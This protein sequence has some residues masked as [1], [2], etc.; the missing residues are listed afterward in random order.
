MTDQ[1]K[2]VERKLRIII[3]DH[4]AEGTAIP[5]DNWDEFTIKQL[6]KVFHSELEK[7]RQETIEIRGIIYCDECKRKIQK[8]HNGKI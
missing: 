6:K 8:I 2:E 1:W 3:Q 7:V 4:N 5:L